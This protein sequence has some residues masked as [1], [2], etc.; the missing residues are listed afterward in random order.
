MFVK[1]LC[2]LYVHKYMIVFAVHNGDMISCGWSWCT[3]EI[4]MIVSVQNAD[5]KFKNVRQ[6]KMMFY[7]RWWK[8][9]NTVPYII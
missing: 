7:T 1:V 5:E 9:C 3:R 2:I 6:D 4:I 8:W